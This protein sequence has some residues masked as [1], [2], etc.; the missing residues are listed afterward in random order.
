MHIS[1]KSDYALRALFH[2]V[3]HSGPRSIAE[4]ARD[5]DIPKRFLEHIMLEMKER[6]W[7]QSSPGRNG[8]YSLG[9]RPEKITMGQVVRHFDGILAPLGCVSVNQY[10]PCPQEP[11]CRFRRVMLDIR[12]YTAKLMDTMSLDLVN[13]MDPV[14]ASESQFVGGAGI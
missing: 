9:Q 10:T 11:R 12:N 5:N 3:N 2:L 13:R 1:A 8:G 14:S 4:I 6:G 7:V